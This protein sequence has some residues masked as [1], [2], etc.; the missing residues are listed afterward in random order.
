MTSLRKLAFHLVWVS[1]LIVCSL[2]MYEKHRYP[3]DA[4][5]PVRN[6]L[7][8]SSVI[9]KHS[10]MHSDTS[11]P[12]EPTWRLP[13]LLRISETQVSNLDPEIQLYWFEFIIV[14]LIPSWLIPGWHLRSG[15]DRLFPRA[16]QFVSQTVTQRAIHHMRSE[17]LLDACKKH[18][19]NTNFDHPD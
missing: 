19:T 4:R 7:Q 2:R 17:L 8:Y 3:S 13:L 15:H 10:F 9:L 1:L 6:R 16:F 11:S 12:L 18:Q 5:R 14:F